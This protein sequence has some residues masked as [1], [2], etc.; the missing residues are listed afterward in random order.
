MNSKMHLALSVLLLV[1]SAATAAGPYKPDASAPRASVPEKY[2]WDLSALFADDEA[3]EAGFSLAQT[4]TAALA[5][6]KGKLTAAATIRAALDDYFSARQAMDR[7]AAYAN[8]KASEDDGVAGYQELRQ[9]ALGL[10]NDF[11]ARTGFIRQE[12]LRLDEAAAKRVL[13]KAA[14]APYRR[15]IEDLR[16]RRFRILGDEAERVLGLAGDNLWSETDL[17]EIPSDIE[18][19]FK[20]ALKDIKLPRIIDDK[21]KLV[22]LS[23]ANYAKY[24][25]SKDRLVRRMAVEGLFGSLKKNEDVLAAILG[26][27]VKRD[28]FLARARGYERSVDAYLDRQDIP[29]AVVENL[30]SSV[31]ENLA[32]LHRYLGLRKKLLGLPDLYLYDLY[33]PLVPSAK[34]DIPFEEA[35]RDVLAAVQPMGPD[36]AAQLSGPDMLGRRMLD[37]YPNKGKESGAYAHSLWGFPQLV[38]LNYMNDIE[39]VSTT[40]HELGHA[41]HGRINNQAHP[42]Q[43]AGYSSLTAEIAS[44]FNEMLLNKHL[45][46]KYRGDPKM[47]LYLLSQLADRIRTTVYRQTLF[48]EFELKI[49]GFAEAGTPI[50]AELLDRTYADLV[51]LYYGPSFTVGP[52]D[53]QEWSYIPHL[54]WKH[55]MFSYAC[56]LASAV[57][58]SEKVAAGDVAAR[59]RYLMMLAQPR[60]EHPVEILVDAGV[61]LMQPEAIAAAARLL[62]QTVAEME[63]LSERAATP[64]K[65]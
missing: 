25:A 32:P 37:V 3:W 4:Q 1:A 40:A 49:H 18:L 48:T 8:L 60:E 64:K 21:G 31:H 5:A 23:L 39:D 45:L 7:V 24:R 27:E 42:V 6:Y 57:T 65:G 12:L 11:R 16:R 26:G 59:E 47:R 56:G 55:Y 22:E 43:D 35:M 20:A 41:M 50:T 51:K 29:A 46:A 62:D 52:N 15:Y 13:A 17:N 28:V 63:K 30:V 58:L 9:R 2:R 33:A 10:G 38:L 54:Y 36:Y 61:D 19:A 34:A 14:L 44:T 53:G